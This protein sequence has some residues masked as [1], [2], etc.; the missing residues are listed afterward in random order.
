MEPCESVVDLLKASIKSFKAPVDSIKAPVDSVEA[1]VGVLREV[2]HSLVCP[3]HA[4]HDCTIVDKTARR[5]L[6][7]LAPGDRGRDQGADLGE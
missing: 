1:L 7:A 5:Q 2:V 4:V 6:A 3:N